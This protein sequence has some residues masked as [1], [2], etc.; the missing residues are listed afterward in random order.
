MMFTWLY[1]SSSRI[2]CN[3]PDY[4]DGMVMYKYIAILC[5]F[6][7]S[8]PVQA[9]W[10]L[11]DLSGVLIEN[12]GFSASYAWWATAY[13]T[14][15]WGL[16][17][18]WKSLVSPVNSVVSCVRGWVAMVWITNP[19]KWSRSA[20]KNLNEDIFNIQETLR[21]YPVAPIIARMTWKPCTLSGYDVP[22][23]TS[24]FVSKQPWGS[25]VYV[26]T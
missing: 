23:Q 17:K 15:H 21:L 24:V 4:I 22:A 11:W 6:K 2:F 20:P 13:P 19:S 8:L 7:R 5:N 18:W 1:L 14:N 9:M 26:V 10:I 3:I 16:S 25:N 12:R